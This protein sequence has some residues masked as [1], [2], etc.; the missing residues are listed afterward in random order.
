MLQKKLICCCCLLDLKFSNSIYCVYVCLLCFFFSFLSVSLDY[1][2]VVVFFVSLEIL[3]L[4][5]SFSLS[6]RNFSHTNVANVF[7]PLISKNFRIKPCHGDDDSLLFKVMFW[8]SS[9][10]KENPELWSYLF[11]SSNVSVR[12]WTFFKEHWNSIPWKSYKSDRNVG[13]R[14]QNQSSDLSSRKLSAKT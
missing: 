4:F 9:L 6:L 5:L 8:H 14:K 10:R 12:F 2:A 7:S 3:V 1:C 13:R 11:S